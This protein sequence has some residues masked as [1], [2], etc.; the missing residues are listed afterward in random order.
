MS[1]C[2]TTASMDAICVHLDSLHLAFQPTTTIIDF[3]SSSKHKG[4]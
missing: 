4:L 1:L 2:G 3:E